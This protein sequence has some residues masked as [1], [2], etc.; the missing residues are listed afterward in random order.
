MG[1]RA[2]RPWRPGTK[3]RQSYNR[4]AARRFAPRRRDLQNESTK[5]CKTTYLTYVFVCYLYSASSSGRDSS[6]ARALVVR[7]R[8]KKARMSV[9]HADWCKSESGSSPR[10]HTNRTPYTR[11]T[12]WRHTNLSASDT[13]PARGRARG[14]GDP[15]TRGARASRRSHLGAPRASGAQRAR[16]NS[17]N[18][19]SMI[20]AHPCVI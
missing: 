3:H 7:K 8:V 6:A 15:A 20:A 2:R 5:A 13:E 16:S 18:T 19:S 17:K 1:Q 10:D 14:L 11:T 9:L 12:H 4:L